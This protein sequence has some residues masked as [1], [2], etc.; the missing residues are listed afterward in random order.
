MKWGLLRTW[1]DA[2]YR[3]L[4]TIIQR[5]SNRDFSVAWRRAG[6]KTLSGSMREKWLWFLDHNF[7]LPKPSGGSHFPEI[8]QRGRALSTVTSFLSLPT[9]HILFLSVTWRCL[10]TVAIRVIFLKYF[11]LSNPV[12]GVKHLLF[13]VENILLQFRR[14]SC[15]HDWDGERR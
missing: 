2:L 10:S 13:R 5:F 7:Y 4:K 1:C 9:K 15:V 8:K 6:N 11:T 3:G 14:Q 12:V